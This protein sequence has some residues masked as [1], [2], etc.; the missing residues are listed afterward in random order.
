MEEQDG[1]GEGEEEG[2]GYDQENSVK[3]S[4]AVHK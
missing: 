4:P 3:S 1:Y 2:E